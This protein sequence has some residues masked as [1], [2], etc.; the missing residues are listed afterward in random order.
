[1]SSFTFR[2][3]EIDLTHKKSQ[4]LDVTEDVRKYLG[5]RGLGSKLLWDRVPAR[6]DPLSPE[7]ILYFGVGPITGFF[8]SV[9]NV[10]AK[11]PLTLLRGQSNMNGRFGVE[12]I[13]AGYNAGLLITGKSDK[14]VYIYI[15]DDKVEIRDASHLWGMMQVEAQYALKQEIRKDLEDQNFVT[16]T[17]GP[18]G[19]NLVRNAIIS[20]DFYHH[21]A[22]LGMG[23]VMGSKNLKAVVVRGTEPPKY[24]NPEK[25]FAL[26]VKFFKEGRLFRVTQ[27]RWGHTVSMPLRYY[28]TTEGVKNKQL[29]WHEVCDLSRPTLLEQGYKVWNDSC[30]LC[31][32]ACKVPYIKRDPPLGPCVG[33]IRH[34][35]AG[36]WN[37]NVLIPGYDTQLYLTPFLDNLGLDNE[38]VSGVVAWLM[39]CFEKGLVKKQE[40]DGIDLTWGNLEAICR[41]AKKIAY[42]EGIGHILADGLKFAARRMGREAEKYA[43]TSKGVAITSYE[44]R[45]SLKDAIQ[46]AVIPF[47]ELHGARGAPIRVALD[48]LTACGFALFEPPWAPDLEQVFGSVESWAIDMINAACDWGL[49]KKEWDIV[50]RRIVMLERCYCLREGYVPREH[51]TLPNRFFDETIYNKYG[52]P[53]Q[54][55]RDDFVNGISQW[56]K[57]LG[58][59][60]DGLPKK[61]TLQELGLEF[62][63]PDIE[64]VERLSL[65]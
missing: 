33:E 3:L 60:E 34:D 26:I 48:S 1:M 27:R 25:L 30:L 61:V 40:L 55:N 9:T 7:N 14:P 37:A 18:A 32:A 57:S 41:I 63:I 58:L 13:Y 54:L 8:G 47:G 39:E 45:G 24:S 11:S 36:G 46:L 59:G 51:D 65:M 38:D 56:Y 44:P 6:V 64:K 12:L 21:A 35:N 2:L 42:R 52:Q 31:P 4:V 20:H 62:V 50:I 5:G 23:A 49:T 28:R 19:E 29:G 10:S 15:K 17:I 53:R 22:R 16:A 43:M